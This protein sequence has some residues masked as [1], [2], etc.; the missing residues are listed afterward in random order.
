MDALPDPL[1]QIDADLAAHYEWATR[2]EPRLRRF[3]RVARDLGLDVPADWVD[4]SAPDV[5]RL[6]ALSAAQFDRLLCLFE[7]LA[8]GRPVNVVITRGGPNLF[9]PI[10]PQGPVQ[11]AVPSSVHMVVPQ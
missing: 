6:G 8:E 1:H 7:D 11:P 9:D 10:A 4:H 2:I 3:D 5:V